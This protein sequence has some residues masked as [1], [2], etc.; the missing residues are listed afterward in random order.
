DAARRIHSDVERREGSCRARRDMTVALPLSRWREL[1]VRLP[2]GKPLPSADLKASLV[3]GTRR[4]F[5]V[6]G[7]YDAL[8]EYNCAHSYAISVALL[9]DTIA[10]QPPKAVHKKAARIK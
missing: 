3:S 2:N 7:N 1:G 6:Y 9:A 4:Y 5:L 10:T 8:L